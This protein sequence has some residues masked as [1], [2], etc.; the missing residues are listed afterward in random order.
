MKLLIPIQDNITEQFITWLENDIKYRLVDEIDVD[1]LLELQNMLDVQYGYQIDMCAVFLDI[2]NTIHHISTKTTYIIEIGNNKI[3][4]GTKI[5]Y[6]T[7]TKLI[8]YGNL[9]IRGRCV[10]SNIFRHIRSN[11]RVYITRYLHG[12]GV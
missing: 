9:N 10:V 5:S 6:S 3:V 11:L 12:L 4:Q 8:N 1:Y 2:L 7:M